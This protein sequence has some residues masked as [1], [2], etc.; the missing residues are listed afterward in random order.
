MSE[1]PDLCEHSKQNTGLGDI[2]GIRRK[3]FLVNQRSLQQELKTQINNV[4]NVP[5]PLRKH[6]TGIKE[7]TL[8]IS[9]G[10]KRLAHCAC[11]TRI[12]ISK[13]LLI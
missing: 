11:C 12:T 8:A 6:K 13:A 9:K 3:L 4:E 1:A 2:F 10:V 5:L 7:I